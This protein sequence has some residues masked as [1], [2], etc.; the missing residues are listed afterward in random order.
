MAAG[1]NPP[2]GTIGSP[3]CWWPATN[4][5]KIMSLFVVGFEPDDLMPTR[6][7]RSRPGASL[8]AGNRVRSI[9]RYFRRATSMA[10][11][12]VTL[13]GRYRAVG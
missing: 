7:P 9:E 6:L 2:L 8:G 1:D 13:A 10:T 4:F 12:A 5:S 11:K 3:G